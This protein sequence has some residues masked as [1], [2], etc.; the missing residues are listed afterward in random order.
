MNLHKKSLDNSMIAHTLMALLSCVLAFAAWTRPN[1]GNSG[2]LVVMLPGKPDSLQRIVWQDDAG[3]VVVERNAAGGAGQKA[4]YWIHSSTTTPPAETETWPGNPQTAALVERLAPLKAARD[5]GP[6][7]ATQLARFGFDHVRQKLTLQDSSGKTQMIEFGGVTFGSG[8]HYARAADQRV[9]LLRVGTVSSLLAGGLALQDRSL[10]GMPERQFM[11]VILRGKGRQ[12]QLS[13][14][15]GND[16][17][18][19]FMADPADPDQ[20][21][22]LASSFVEG[23]LMQQASDL[24][25]AP[26]KPE[27]LSVDFVF[28]RQVVASVQ[29]WPCVQN[30]CIARSS[31]HKRALIIPSNQLAQLLQDGEKLLAEVKRP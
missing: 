23:L 4:K 29:F 1:L 16:L 6:F 17:E 11:S 3:Q 13:Q 2:Q 5:L 15:H 21:L 22:E 10:V 31:H 19:V 9:Y 20:R 24:T 12:R 30:V 8:D 25:E 7:D 26:A 28:D 18:K 14:R 27:V